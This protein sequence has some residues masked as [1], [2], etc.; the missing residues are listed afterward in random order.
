MT[1]VI[2]LL[3]AGAALLALETVLPGMIAGIVGFFCLVGGVAVAYVDL[4]TRTANLV[5]LITVAGLVVGWVI[6]LKYFPD[7]R[8]AKLFI[9]QRTIGDVDAEQTG[10]I[11]QSG[12]ALTQLRPSGVALI[13]GQRVDVVTEGGMIDQGTP[14]KVIAVEGLRTIVRAV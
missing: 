1:T 10:L 5:L 13:N 8:A 11:G 12:A 6:Y 3:L 4:D 14:V 2:L 7:S 9:S